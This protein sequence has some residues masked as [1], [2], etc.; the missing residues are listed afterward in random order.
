VRLHLHHL[1]LAGIALLP[2]SGFANITPTPQVSAKA[3]DLPLVKGA[4]TDWFGEVQ[5]NLAARVP[6]V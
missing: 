6:S 4:T 5:K 2:L 1:F 3:V